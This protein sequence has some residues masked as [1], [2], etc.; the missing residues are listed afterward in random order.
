MARAPVLILV[1]F[2]FI[3]QCSAVP[4]PHVVAFGKWISVKWMVGVDENTALDLRVRAIYVDTRLKEFT[5][6]LPHEV[7]DR[8]FVVQRA[9]RL[10]DTLP[11]EPASPAHW[12]WQRGGWLLVDRMSG[13]I[14]QLNLPEFDAL[15]SVT[16]WYRDYGAYCGI[17]DDGK[18]VYAM[19]AQLGRRKP[20]L[21][22]SLGDTDADGDPDCAGPSWPR[23]PARVTF[24]TRQ[25]A[26]FTYLVHGHAVDAIPSEH[27]E[28][29]GTE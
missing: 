15:Y 23:K 26:Q 29:S 7:T 25:E 5:V 19:V 2:V 8:L 13:H 10:N 3:G 28:D 11:A 24:S 6:G 1:S 12:Q 17:S 14:S 4:K 21:K 9:F 16:N 18:K 20:I 22:K 27:E